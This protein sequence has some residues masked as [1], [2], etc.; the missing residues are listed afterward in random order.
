MGSRAYSLIE[1]KFQ[2]KSKIYQ[3][4]KKHDFDLL[5]IQESEMK[6]RELTYCP[7]WNVWRGVAERIRTSSRSLEIVS[8]RW[9]IEFSYRRISCWWLLLYTSSME[10]NLPRRQTKCRISTRRY[11]GEFMWLIKSTS[12]YWPRQFEVHSNELSWWGQRYNLFAHPVAQ[13]VVRSRYGSLTPQSL[14]QDT[15]LQEQDER[16]DS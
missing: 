5:S 14:G 10:K 12:R 4:E 9:R 15:S 2:G 6:E 8:S 11:S 16:C 7:G 3:K 1:Q 13:W